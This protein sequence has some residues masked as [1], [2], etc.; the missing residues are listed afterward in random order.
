MEISSQ[1]ELWIF[2]NLLAEKWISEKDIE[3]PMFERRVTMP[4]SLP[5]GTAIFKIESDGT[6]GDVISFSI[7]HSSEIRLFQLLEPA[8]I[9]KFKQIVLSSVDT[10]YNENFDFFSYLQPYYLPKLRDIGVMEILGDTPIQDLSNYGVKSRILL[11][12]SDPVQGYEVPQFWRV[13]KS[14]EALSR[15]D[16]R[17][18][19]RISYLRSTICDR[20]AKHAVIESLR[21]AIIA[22]KHYADLLDSMTS[23]SKIEYSDEYLELADGLYQL[24]EFQDSAV[25]YSKCLSHS[26]YENREEE[27]RNKILAALKSSIEQLEPQEFLEYALFAA[28][29]ARGHEEK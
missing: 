20:L 1:P 25:F 26:N 3:N 4:I 2:S 15:N 14:L 23:E 29:V 7:A 18:N 5:S 11:R 24:G 8:Q 9:S 13:N 21:C 19:K 10:I 12:I 6:Q 27:V 17:N 28:R 22:L 16:T